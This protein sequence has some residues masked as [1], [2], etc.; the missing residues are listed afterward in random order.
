[1]LPSFLAEQLSTRLP[2]VRVVPVDLT[3]FLRSGEPEVDYKH[4]AIFYTNLIMSMVGEGYAWSD[5]GLS[6][7][8]LHQYRY[9]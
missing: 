7:W 3:Y 8:H 1:M 5:G 4:M 9:S 6:R 2:G